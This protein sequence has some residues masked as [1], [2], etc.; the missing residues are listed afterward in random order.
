MKGMR[1]GSRETDECPGTFTRDSLPRFWG[2][3]SAHGQCP[4]WL[5]PICPGDFW[6]KSPSQSHWESRTHSPSRHLNTWQQNSSKSLPKGQTL[7]WQSTEKQN[8]GTV[9]AVPCAPHRD[10]TCH[11]RTNIYFYVGNPKILLCFWRVLR[12]ETENQMFPVSR[13][14]FK[15]NNEV[16]FHSSVKLAHPA[17]LQTAFLL[18]FQNC[19][20]KGHY[21][22]SWEALEGAHCLYFPKERPNVLS[23]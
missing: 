3:D 13:E 20:N 5:L 23:V 9:Q 2:A 1:A 22:C 21:H 18:E 14:Q 12:Q 15:Q 6:S 8:V 19:L 4:L 16:A 10:T 11:M 17:L 7:M